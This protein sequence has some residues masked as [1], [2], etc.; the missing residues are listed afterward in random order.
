MTHITP[1]V[2]RARSG[3]FDNFAINDPGREPFYVHAYFGG[4]AQQTAGLQ[5]SASVT[6]RSGPSFEVFNTRQNAP[7][8]PLG[9]GWTP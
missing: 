7:V 1:K 8:P 5:V 3:A 2:G 4:D 6:M 9:S